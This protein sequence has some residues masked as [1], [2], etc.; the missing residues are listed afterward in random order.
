MKAALRQTLGILLFILFVFRANA[1]TWYVPG[2]VESEG[3]SGARFSSTMVLGNL[4]S[5]GV[6]VTISFIPY[7]EKMVPEPVTRTLKG[8]ETLEIPAVLNGL[9]G[10]S[11]DAGTLKVTSAV[12]L[13]ISLVTANIADPS[14]TYGVSVAPVAEEVLL[15]TGETG[16]A[17]WVTE[18]ALYRTNLALVLAAAETAVEIR[19][20][21][22]DGNLRGETTVSSSQPVSWQRRLPELFPGL[23]L[24]LGRI[25]M[26]VLKGL[27]TGYTAAADN[28]TSDGIASSFIRLAQGPPDLLLNGAANTPGKNGTY[29]TTDVRVLNPS[30]EGVIVTLRSTG[31]SDERTFTVPIRARGVT[32]IRD[33]FGK[34]AF[35]FPEGTAGAVRVESATPVIAAAVTRTPAPEGSTGSFGSFV[36]AVAYPGSFLAP[37]FTGSIVG[38]DHVSGTKGF[39]TN[40]A[41]L[42]GPEGA[43]GT[44]VLRNSSGKE[45][46][47]ASVSLISGQWWQRAVTEWFPGISSLE[48]ARVDYVPRSGSADLY[49][50]RADNG[51]G[52]GVVLRPRVVS[53]SSS[54]PGDIP[55]GPLQIV[56]LGDSLT[57]GDG[58]EAERGGYPGRLR[59]RVEGVRPGS[60]VTNFGLSGWTSTDL[61]NGQLPDALQE[62]ARAKL[63]GR[64]PVAM[65]WIGSNDLWGLYEYGV[66]SDQADAEDLAVFTGNIDTILQQLK[67]SGAHLFIALLDDQSKRPV[68]VAGEAFPGITA[69]ELQRMSQQAIRYNA[70]IADRAAAHGATTV[71]FFNTTIFVDWATLAD[72]GNHPNAAGYEIIVEKWFAALLSRL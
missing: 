6:T 32:E 22:G 67:Q 53:G 44:L 27:A 14:G 52:D 20:F 37:P 70:A 39:R 49:A 30:G 1:E 26:K 69:E 68:A 5:E 46:G 9:F 13:A 11:G 55:L 66:G 7:Q 61:I 35:G 10:L 16:H 3:L 41:F 24:S 40:I 23:S 33:V 56:T 65:V 38:V 58:D 12:P 64:T 2:A 51:T 48:S 36:T 4:S 21:D 63:E 60:V 62:I 71:D 15:K 54:G 57:A 19:I 59:A 28:S 50:A 25:E 31:V 8:G 17:V 18:D 42:A 29:Y 45:I 72:D 43:E 47:N 34:G